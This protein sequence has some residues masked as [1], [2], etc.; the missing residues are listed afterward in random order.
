MIDELKYLSKLTDIFLFAE[1]IWDLGLT[2]SNTSQMV[3]R[4]MLGVREMLIDKR[5]WKV[6]DEEKIREAVARVENEMLVKASGKIST[7]KKLILNYSLVMICSAFDKYEEH[8]LT[9]L[10]DTNL[11]LCCWLKKE[12]IISTFIYKTPKDRIK[13]FMN[14][15]NLK[16]SELFNFSMFNSEV[17]VKYKGFGLSDF[18]AIY[19]KRDK[20]AHEDYPVIS[21]IEELQDIKD[22]FDKLIFVWSV[23]FRTKWGLKSK[24]V[25]LATNS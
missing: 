10:L 19:K 5:L 22:L 21:T 1:D 13:V 24:I 8:L 20:A 17:Q 2:E 9:L 23:L 18:V 3:A 16:E 12:E 7:Y 11:N 4:R 25:E 14:R 6:T 15:L